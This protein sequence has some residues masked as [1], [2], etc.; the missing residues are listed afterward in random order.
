LRIVLLRRKKPL[1]YGSAL[2]IGLSLAL[3]VVLFTVFAWIIGLNPL[4]VL[5]TISSSFV[6]PGTVKDFLVLTLLGYALLVAFKGSLWNIGAEGQFHIALLPTV[7]V[8]LI[9]FFT[10][11]QVPAYVSV[12]VILLSIV[13]ATIAGALW[14][15]LAGAIKAYAGVDEVP[16]TL[17]LNYIAYYIG[18]ILILGP[19]QGKYVYGYKRTDMLPDPYRVSIIVRVPSTGNPLL[20]NV[21]AYVRELIMYFAWILGLLV[22]VLLVR[23]LFNNTTLGLRIKVLGSNPDYLVTL[24]YDVKKLTVVTFMISG[25]IVGFTAA[26]YFHGYLYRLEYPLE[27]V[28]GQYG[29]LAIL[30]TWLSLLEI[31]LIPV[32][33][34][35]VASLIMGSQRLVALP[36]VK[37]A[38]E[39]AGF[40]GVETSFRLLMFGSI[41]LTY[42]IMRFLQEYELKVI[43]E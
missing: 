18:N 19:F 20:D 2:T 41:L 12:A 35:I 26:L 9:C 33:A 24:G 29:Y 30:V 34:Y 38:L 32:S 43:R 27:Y 6:F 3:G 10:L 39:A 14:G 5:Y 40:Y 8:T 23:W 15:G 11:E 16:V 31:R 7:Y 13:L 36:E 4:L 28:S 22:V 1:K 42:S 25:A 37:K 21:F 17:I